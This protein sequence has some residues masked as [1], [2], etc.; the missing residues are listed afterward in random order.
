MQK[1]NKRN[2]ARRIF[3]KLTSLVIKNKLI[4]KEFSR[5]EAKK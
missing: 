5:Q 3:T 1:K 2:V 4:E